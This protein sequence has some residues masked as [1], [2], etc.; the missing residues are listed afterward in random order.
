M[1]T[2]PAAQAQVWLDALQG[3]GVPAR[4]WPLMQTEPLPGVQA[5]ARGE[6][7][8]SE[9]VFFTSPAAVQ[10][11]FAGEPMAWPTRCLAICVGPGT[12]QA[13][14][15]AGVPHV[16][17]PAPEAQ[18]FDSE[19]LWPLLQAHQNWQGRRVLW[20]RGDGGR[21]WLIEQL[22]AQ[23]AE[24]QLLSVYRRVLAPHDGPSQ[25]RLAQSLAEPALWLF[26]SSEA[27]T[28][29]AALA[30]STHWPA[31]QALTT[32]PRIDQAAQLLGMQSR[33]VSPQ[34]ERVAAAWR[35]WSA[36]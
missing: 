26:S 22:R 33:V 27:L 19:A 36:P 34:P 9:A 3:L 25:R 10:A 31:V 21:D 4:N 18:Q 7:M 16:L 29:L 5:T 8:R 28:H 30:P 12:S 20:L 2:R 11:L 15:L 17:S 35:T 6:V 24:V 14:H 23:G 32:H 13:L 1:L